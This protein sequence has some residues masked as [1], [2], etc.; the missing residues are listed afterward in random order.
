MDNPR[1]PGADGELIDEAETAPAEAGR[2]GGN[3]A[4]EVAT[5]AEL[6]EVDDPEHRTRVTK[7]AK[8]DHDEDQRSAGA[9]APDNGEGSDGLPPN[10]V[11]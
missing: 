5:D 11:G 10:T 8:I 4:T 2:S 1:N 9:R 6:A 7:G 3:L